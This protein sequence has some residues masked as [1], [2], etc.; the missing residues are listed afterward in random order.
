[1]SLDKR[2]MA[3]LNDIAQT[4]LYL[5]VDKLAKVFNVSRRT[6][7]NDLE[8]INY[9][10]K[11][12]RL[13]EVQHIRAAGVYLDNQTKEVVKRRLLLTDVHYYELSPSERRAWTV[14]YILAGRKKIFL[15]DVAALTRVSRNT[16][17]EDVK[18]LRT[19]LAG[20]RL[21]IRAARNAGYQINGDENNKRRALIHYLFEITPQ[22]GWYGLISPSLSISAAN[23]EQDDNYSLFSYPDLKYLY[24][25]LGRCENRLGIQFADEEFN[26]LVIRFFLFIQRMKR[27]QFVSVDPLE[28]KVISVTEEY[29]AAVFLRKGIKKLLQMTVPDDEVYYFAKHLLAAKVNDHFNLHDGSQEVKKLRLV[30]KKMMEEFQLLAAVSFSDL[31]QM[32]NNLL[33]HLKPAYYRVKYGIDME[34]APHQPVED[35]FPEIFQ[36]TKKVIHHFE[37]FVGKTIS[38]REI[39]YIAIH[40]G[41]WLEREGL[42]IQARK[43]MLIVC[44]GGLGTSRLLQIQLEGLFSEVDI[45]GTVSLR[46]YEKLLL[47]VDFIVS[48]VPLS[49][50]GVP[51]FLVRPLLTNH[52]KARLLQQVT[53]LYVDSSPGHKYAIETVIRVVKWH[54]DIRDDDKLRQALKQYLFQPS[55]HRTDNVCKP[56]LCE[57]ITNEKIVFKDKLETW[58][59][60]IHEAALP[61]LN[62]GCITPG[63]VAAMIDNIVRQGPYMVISP[64]VAL[65]HGT[66]GDGVKKL[67]M[68]WLQLTEPVDFLGKKVRIV[69]ALAAEGNEKHLRAL[70]QLTAM[71]SNDKKAVL[72]A[73]NKQ[74]IFEIMQKYSLENIEET[75]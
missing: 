68:S 8:K 6:V 2:S 46:E 42:S 27:G 61:L 15:K 74:T 25:L 71:F 45:T 12:N 23:R 1:M 5:P 58:R 54:A 69:I 44:T 51:V 56:S 24:H 47:A 28:K 57:L 10:L 66:A 73:E 22:N 21:G 48:T 60:A 50:R 9:W 14:V 20:Y 16:A 59:E 26:I 38:E 55:F 19:E 43:K 67:G 3:I 13:N 41:G 29:R 64:L 33:M 52:E 35:S 34:E 32:E 18:L 75:D 7:Y 70:S 36:L 37:D 30:V 39:A 65:P 11:V 31:L 53:A 72:E 17:L 62:D 40:F 4:D 49:D 63:Y